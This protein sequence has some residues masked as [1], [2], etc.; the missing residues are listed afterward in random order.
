M[1]R[2]TKTTLVILQA[3]EDTQ[4]VFSKTLRIILRSPTKYAGPP[5]FPESKINSTFEEYNGNES[6]KRLTCDIM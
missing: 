5:K 2:L 6:C 1:N 3:S 4:I